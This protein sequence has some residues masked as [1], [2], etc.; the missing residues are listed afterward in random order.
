MSFADFAVAVEVTVGD[1]W[2]GGLKES[3]GSALLDSR[4]IQRR[5]REIGLQIT[6]DYRGKTPHLICILKG[7][8]L[9][10]ADLI[11]AIELE[12]SMDFIAAASYGQ[13]TKSSGDVRIIKDLDESIEDKDVLLVEDI[14]DTGFTL[15]YLRKTLLSR[16]P[17]SLKIAALLN[18]PSRREIDVPVDYVGFEIPDEFV[19]GYGLD[20][21][22]RY[23][24]LPDIRI[25]RID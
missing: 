9:F 25:L 17:R 12:V 4:T 23:R 7:A 24:N 6:E 10:H 20:Y 8:I 19:V 11:R 21:A 22:Q 14:A 2:P 18:K 1:R 13:L 3:I 15:H 16:N 5:V